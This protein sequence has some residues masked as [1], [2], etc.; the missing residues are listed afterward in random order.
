MEPKEHGKNAEQWLYAA[1]K[2][3]GKAEPRVGLEGRLLA[4]L[5][6]E[7][8][9]VSERGNWWRA[10]AGVAATL[11][12]GWVIF[13]GIG[14]HGTQKE[15][16]AVHSPASGQRQSAFPSNRELAETAVSQAQGKNS[17]SRRHALRAADASEPRLE[18]FP[19]PRP[20]SEQEKML[21]WYVQELP[22]EAKQVALAQ[23]ALLKKD[24]AEFEKAYGPL[25]H[26]NSYSQ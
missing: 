24:L 6:A 17:P 11:V 8:E 26:P 16:A 18:Q 10:L 20:L 19:A 9:H 21:A 7:K 3:Y 12:V 23:A 15:I 13:L 14:H 4:N 2:Q 1:L 25:D 22:Q 5:R